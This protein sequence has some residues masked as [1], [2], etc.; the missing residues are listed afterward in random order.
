MRAEDDFSW[1]YWILKLGLIFSLIVL[2]ANIFVLTVIKGNYYKDLARA[3]KVVQSVIPAPRAQ[4]LDRKGRV[5]A[6]SIYQY[7]DSSRTFPAYHRVSYSKCTI[8]D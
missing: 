1:K 2:L 6:K 3:N 8:P 4:I 5:V 7:F